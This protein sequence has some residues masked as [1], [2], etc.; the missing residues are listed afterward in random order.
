MFYV[1]AAGIVHSKCRAE[2]LKE[3]MS[4]ESLAAVRRI[5]VRSLARLI[6][7]LF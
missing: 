1:S 3:D 4:G 6:A 7:F 5:Q 2:M